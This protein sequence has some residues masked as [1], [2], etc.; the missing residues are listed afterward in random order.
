MRDENPPHQ[1]AAAAAQLELPRPCLL[2]PPPDVWPLCVCEVP[3][4][5]PLPRACPSAA[6]VVWVWVWVWVWRNSHA[7]GRLPS[8]CSHPPCAALMVFVW[9]NSQIALRQA[10]YIDD[11]RGPL[12]L[13][14]LVVSAMSGA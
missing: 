5:A 9:R 14:V 3:C 1:C 6:L 2:P 7:L 8:P 10:S 12:L 13:A 4:D 11:R